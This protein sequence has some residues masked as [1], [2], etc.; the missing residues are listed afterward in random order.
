[1]ATNFIVD[2]NETNFE[3]EV[4]SYS[5]NTPVVVDF[6]APWCQPCKVIGP[7]LESLATEAQGNFRLAR[8]NVDEN[9]TLALRFG[10]RSIP[11]VKAFSA[12]QVVTEFVG[13]QPETRIREFVSKLAPPSEAALALEKANSLLI[14]QDWGRA[15]QIFRKLEETDAANP[16]IQ[17]G[18][19][20]TLLGQ[21]KAPEAAFI[22]RNFPAS[23]E[24]VS[25]EKL[26]P[27]AE[28]I[29][30][31]THAELPEETDLDAAFHTAIRLASRAK[32]EAAMD[33][34][35]DLLRQDKRYRSGKA[36]QIMLS[37]LELYGSE[38]PTGRQ[39]RAE[40]ASVLF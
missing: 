10:V 30:K 19:A 16:V 2:A 32:F 33:G 26:V 28:T 1:M 13:L 8:V 5:L 29:V 18:L 25:A 3:Y 31:M 20:K 9:P 11:T 21:G 39:Y 15:E 40:L 14:E 12:G 35:L 34:L 17:L 4:I 27:L 24:Y 7:L 6:W 38:D 22:L 36:R 37:I 23:K